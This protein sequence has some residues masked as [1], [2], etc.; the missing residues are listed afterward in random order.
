MH[1]S[2]VDENVKFEFQSNCAEMLGLM[3]CKVLTFNCSCEHARSLAFQHHTM[4]GSLLQLHEK[5]KKK[6]PTVES[7]DFSLYRHHRKKKLFNMN[8]STRTL[9][10]CDVCRVHNCSIL[11]NEMGKNRKREREV[12]HSLKLKLNSQLGWLAAVF[13]SRLWSCYDVKQ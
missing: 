4:F 7:V 13:N 5:I 2:G 10:E 6:L 3:L 8:S 11:K 1:T 12:D 9:P